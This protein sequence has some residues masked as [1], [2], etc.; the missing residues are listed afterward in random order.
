M[1]WKKKKKDTP[2]QKKKKQLPYLH[3]Q[4]KKAGTLVILIKNCCFIVM[5]EMSCITV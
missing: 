5:G 1:V 3:F 4:E 2:P